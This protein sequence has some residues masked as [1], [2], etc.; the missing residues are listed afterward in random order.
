MPGMQARRQKQNNATQDCNLFKGVGT[1]KLHWPLSV[2]EG[3]SYPVSIYR[4]LIENPIQINLFGEESGQIRNIESQGQGGKKGKWKVP[5]WKGLFWRLRSQWG[6]T[7]RH[8]LGMTSWCCVHKRGKRKEW[9]RHDFVKSLYGGFFILRSWRAMLVLSKTIFPAWELNFWF[10]GAMLPAAFGTGLQLSVF[11]RTGLQMWFL[12]CK[13]IWAR[14]RIQH[15]FV[16]RVSNGFTKT[17]R[18][19]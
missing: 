9:L 14:L 18:Y 15:A 13:M 19:G 10:F 6:K 4:I 16:C 1:Y 2:W 8:D 7:K 3:H 11:F 5:I 12:V 17:E